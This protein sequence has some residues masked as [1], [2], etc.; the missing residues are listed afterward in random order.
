MNVNKTLWQVIGVAYVVMGLIVLFN[1]K[2]RHVIARA[3]AA[4]H[5]RWSRRLPWLYGPK[6]YRELH[7]DEGVWRVLAPL[8]GVLFV[9]I[10]L[11]AILG[12]GVD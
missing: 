9:V 10:G 4:F 3:S 5:G 7:S 1:P 6:G 11:M 2:V 8:M 12:V